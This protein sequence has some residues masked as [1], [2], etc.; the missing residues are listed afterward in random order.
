MSSAITSFS[1]NEFTDQCI[2]EINQGNAS[3]IT[4][5]QINNSYSKDLPS[6]CTFSKMKENECKL[7]AES[8][9]KTAAQLIKISSVSLGIFA[10]L[11]AIFTF[12]FPIT[13][14]ATLLGCFISYEFFMVLLA[15]YNEVKGKQNENKVTNFN[16]I[17]Q[18]AKFAANRSNNR[19]TLI[20]GRKNVK[21]LEVAT[22]VVSLLSFIGWWF[23]IVSFTTCQN[24][25]VA[26]LVISLA[27]AKDTL[28][29]LND[30]PAHTASK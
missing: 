15:L 5:H 9:Q 21:T 10:I 29:H 28:A 11:G 26:G 24:I 14:S 17:S 20:S 3:F 30:S 4:I 13:F 18:A 2:K 7:L 1:S 19:D 8:Y 12:A 16:F 22:G 27:T 23:N 25:S 6:L